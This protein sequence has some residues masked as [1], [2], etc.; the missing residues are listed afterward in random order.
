MHRDPPSPSARARGELDP[1]AA[2]D[3]ADE[4]MNGR[5]RADKFGRELDGDARM[6]ANA[7]VHLGKRRLIGNRQREVMQADIGLAIESHGVCGISGAPEGQGHA[8]VGDEQGRVRFIPAYL[9]EAQRPA[10][11]ARGFV[12]V[13]NGKPDVVHAVRQSVSQSSVLL[14]RQIE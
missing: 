2:G 1:E 14:E 3:G 11:E 6:V 7:L 13:A 12:Q 8:A 9:L 5:A 4:V 10:E